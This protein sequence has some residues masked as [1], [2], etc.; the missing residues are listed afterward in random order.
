MGAS[1]GTVIFCANS[2]H[3]RGIPSFLLRGR[4]GG[5]DIARKL[6]LSNLAKKVGNLVYEGVVGFAGFVCMKIIFGF[7]FVEPI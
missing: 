4:G 5:H 7:L 6:D 1:S 3:K 2:C